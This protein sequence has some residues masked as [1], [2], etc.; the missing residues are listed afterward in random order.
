MISWN[1]TSLR[2]VYK[3]LVSIDYGVYQNR[4]VLNNN[5]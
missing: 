3:E 1:G 5:K 2:F 4:I